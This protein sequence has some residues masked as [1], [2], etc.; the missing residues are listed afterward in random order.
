MNV[1]VP[2]KPAMRNKMKLATCSD[3]EARHLLLW[4]WVRSDDRPV[5]GFSSRCRL[6]SSAVGLVSV[7]LAGQ[8][9]AIGVVDEPIENGVGDSRIRCLAPQS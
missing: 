6:P 4:S 1:R 8:F 9:D 3:L 7:G 5:S 2:T